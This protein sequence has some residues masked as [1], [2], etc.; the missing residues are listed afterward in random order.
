MDECR[1]EFKFKKLLNRIK[2][3]A[4][5]HRKSH[6]QDDMLLMQENKLRAWCYTH[7]RYEPA[8]FLN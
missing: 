3:E 5:L 1:D 8:T 4:D 7:L 6:D 2:L